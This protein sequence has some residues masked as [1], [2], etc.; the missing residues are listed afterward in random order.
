MKGGGY[1][2]PYCFE[3]K[4]KAI[5]EIQIFAEQELGL[6]KTNN[7]SSYYDQKGKPILWVVTASE[8]YKLKAHEWV[9]PVVGSFSYKGFFEKENAKIEQRE[10]EAKGLDT[11]ISE[12]S[13]WSTLGYLNDP[14]LSSM[15]E[16]DEG[17]LAELII[18]E[19]THATVYKKNDV[20]F[21]EN[22]ADFVG[23]YGAK[24]YLEKKFGKYSKEVNKYQIKTKFEHELTEHIS[25]ET[26]KLAGL[27]A[28]LEAKKVNFSERDSLKNEAI[29]KISLKSNQ[30]RQKYY[31]KT[32]Q[33]TAKR[34]LNNAYFVSYLMYQG[35]Q[36]EF[37]NEFETKFK[38]NFKA[39][40]AF[41]KSN[42]SLL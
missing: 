33:I 8:K 17:E 15:L 23:N 3:K 24:L 26:K 28:H 10:L 31:P 36:N 38:S 37:K 40:I 41:L 1:P 34:E 29:K 22:L 30:I 9:F 20:S 14:I 13:A 27:Y 5:K 35:K 6:D 18:H 12:V 25:N 19:L 42:E 32:T 21:N 16:K 4:I 7:Y 2:F 11:R 39:Y